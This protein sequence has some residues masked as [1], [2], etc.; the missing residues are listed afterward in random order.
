MVVNN[1]NNVNRLRV[2][3]KQTICLS[4]TKSKE[5]KFN[6]TIFLFFEKTIANVLIYP[7]YFRPLP[8]LHISLLRMLTHSLHPPIILMLNKYRIIHFFEL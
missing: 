2:M 4:S 6:K 8:R 5:V 1:G 3:Q 7:I